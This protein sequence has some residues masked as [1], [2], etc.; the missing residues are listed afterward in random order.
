MRQFGSPVADVCMPRPFLAHQAMFD[1]RFEPGRWYYFKS[2]DV[3]ELTDEII[4]ITV[5]HSLAD[6]VTPDLFPDLADGWRGQ[7]GRATTSRP[8][9][10]VRPGSPTTSARCTQVREGFDAEREWVRNFWSALEPWHDGVYV[11]FLGAMKAPTGSVRPMGRRK[12]DRLKA[13][14]RKYDPENFFRIN[15]NISPN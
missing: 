9:V 7:P 10:G 3:P 4:D 6:R 1:P 13:L 5:E 2:F 8:S 15:Q 12:Y 11:N 14:K